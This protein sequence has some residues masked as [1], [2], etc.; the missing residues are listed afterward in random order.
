M[1]GKQEEEIPGAAAW[2]FSNLVAGLV[3]KVEKM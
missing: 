1:K 3:R 2:Y